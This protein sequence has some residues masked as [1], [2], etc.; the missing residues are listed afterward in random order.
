M[1]FVESELNYFLSKYIMKNQISV[2]LMSYIYA[3]LGL[4][5]ESRR[6][7]FQDF[8]T[9]T[10]F[11]KTGTRKMILFLGLLLFL[12][13]GEG[14]VSQN[15]LLINE[16]VLKI[17]PNTLISAESDLMNETSGEIT[18][19]G[20]VLLKANLFNYGGLGFSPSQ[21]GYLRFE[22]NNAQLISGSN[23][24]NFYDV[25]F[26][27][28]LD[29]KT[30]LLDND[31]N[32]YGIANFYNGII[33]N[34][35]YIG[36]FTFLE[37]ASHVNT[38]NN[39]YVEGFVGR[40]GNTDFVFPI[41][42]NGHYRFSGISS[43]IHAQNK[44]RAAYYLSNSHHDY[45][46]DLKS[47]RIEAI[48]DQEYWIVE[49]Q[50]ISDE[51]IILSL[52]W[53]SQTTPD[54]FM[55]AASNESLSILKWDATANMWQDEGGYIEMESNTISTSISEGGVFTLGMLKSDI[56]LPCE[57]VVYNTVT[58]NDDGINDYFMIDRSDT[59]CVENLNVK[60]FNRWGVKVFETDNYG[61]GGDVFDGYSSGRLT[62]GD[63]RLPTGAY[64]YVLEY[65]YDDGEESR[66]HKQTGFLHL[67]GN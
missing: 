58:P 46:H 54:M 19:D 30:F 36:Y 24:I 49:K 21:Q 25:L 15:G 53:D 18:N 66:G 63:N 5:K 39:S 8:H 16:G 20:E 28:N 50:F 14:V 6:K 51:D 27:N 40:L 4:S 38:S 44:Y 67:I 2:L 52:S 37:N 43:M 61:K 47:G 31:I 59:D 48:N 33:D 57:I 17:Q 34:V 64:F 32:I 11:R 7:T 26:A 10:T 60:I 3:F 22:G 29:G 35:N 23:P 12:G 65:E 42:E 1:D 45:S 13:S 41:G 55:Q 56:I 9:E 62:I